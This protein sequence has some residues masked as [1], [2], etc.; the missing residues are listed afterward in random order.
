[1]VLAKDLEA[2]VKKHPYSTRRRSVYVL[3][4][5]KTDLETWVTR[6]RLPPKHVRRRYHDEWYREGELFFYE[7]D[8]LPRQILSIAEEENVRSVALTSTSRN[9]GYNTNAKYD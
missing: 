6:H 7:F 9:A 3:I 4:E 2:M 8:L 1:M 5:P